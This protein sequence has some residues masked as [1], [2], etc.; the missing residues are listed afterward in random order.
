MILVF[1][2]LLLS[3]CGGHLTVSNRGCALKS[4]RLGDG[5]EEVI[6][7]EKIWHKTHDGAE[8]V[9]L[10]RDLLASENID[11]ARI[12]SLSYHIGQDLFDQLLSVLPFIRRSQIVVR[13]SYY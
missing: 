3:S 7:K 4:A 11:C 5:S 6:L 1:A 2:L 8:K 12:K 9:V 10:L 13:A